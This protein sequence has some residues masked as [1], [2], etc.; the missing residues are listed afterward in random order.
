MFNSF[1]LGS[2]ADSDLHPRLHPPHWRL[3][4]TDSSSPPGPSAPSLSPPTRAV[5]ALK[6]AEA[7]PD[8]R[9]VLRCVKK[10]LLSV[11]CLMHHRKPEH[12]SR[13]GRWAKR[14]MR[15]QR[16]RRRWGRNWRFPL[17]RTTA[18]KF[19]S[20]SSVLLFWRADV[21]EFN[22]QQI[23]N[24]LRINIQNKVLYEDS[25]CDQSCDAVKSNSSYTAPDNQ[26]E[27]LFSSLS[28]H[29]I[30]TSH[31]TQSLLVRVW[32]IRRHVRRITYVLLMVTVI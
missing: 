20:P 2:Q 26:S 32:N 6:A 17:H 3:S 8:E 24:L 15:K 23:L 14:T 19:S 7:P 28:F 5:D 29:L 21:P 10:Q 12:T 31:M 30:I 11:C 13:R 25:R 27:Q 16:S 1:S 9:R 4:T 22:Q 18:I